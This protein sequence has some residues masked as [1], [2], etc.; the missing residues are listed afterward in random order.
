MARRSWV[1]STAAVWP[2]WRRCSSRCTWRANPTTTGEVKGGAG[3]E[4]VDG[5]GGLGIAAIHYVYIDI[6]YLIYNNIYIYICFIIF[7]ARYVPLDILIQKL[8]YVCCMHTHTHNNIY[9]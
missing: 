7:N 6:M 3:S 1:A 4:G 5:G 2:S 9:I 8:V